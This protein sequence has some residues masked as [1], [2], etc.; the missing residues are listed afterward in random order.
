MVVRALKEMGYKNVAKDFY[1]GEKIRRKEHMEEVLE[2]EQ[3]IEERESWTD[4]Y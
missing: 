1:E 4:D 2:D 3:E